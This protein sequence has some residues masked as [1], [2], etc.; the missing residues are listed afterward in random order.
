MIARH[1]K[2][3]SIGFGIALIPTAVWVIFTG[4]S[5][6][7]IA[8]ALGSLWILANHYFLWRLS[9]SV[10]KSGSSSGSVMGPLMLK[11]PVLYVAGGAMFFIPGFKVEGVIAA[12]TAYIT[13]AALLFLFRGTNQKER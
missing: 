3:L 12:F 2:R 1:L 4:R 11:F 9:L 13:V 5:P 7:L 8:L 10:A 6:W